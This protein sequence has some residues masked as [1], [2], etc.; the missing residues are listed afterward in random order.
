MALDTLVIFHELRE[1]RKD[2]YLHRLVSVRHVAVAHEKKHPAFRIS[3]VGIQDRIQDIPAEGK[4]VVVADQ[5]VQLFQQT[6]GIDGIVSEGD[7]VFAET[8]EQFIRGQPRHLPRLEIPI[9]LHGLERLG[10]HP[11]AT[12]GVAA[13]TRLDDAGLVHVSELLVVT[14]EL[15]VGATEI[16]CKVLI[17]HEA[18]RCGFFQYSRQQ[19]RARTV[20]MVESGDIID[21]VAER[22]ERLCR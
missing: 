11:V 20:Y 9:V 4:V 7:E 6:A 22:L 14:D 12:A 19:Y 2:V 21:V 13:A 17:V 16:H 10:G 15:D 5:V 8:G 18:V 1:I 3:A